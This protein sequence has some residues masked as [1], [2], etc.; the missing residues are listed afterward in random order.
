MGMSIQHRD[1]L[2]TQIPLEFCVN[3]SSSVSKLV[4]ASVSVSGS[5]KP[6][7][8]EVIFCVDYIR[9]VQTT[10]T[11]SILRIDFK[12]TRLVF[13]PKIKTTQVKMKCTQTVRRK[14]IEGFSISISFNMGKNVLF[15][16]AN[17]L[18]FLLKRFCNF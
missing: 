14:Q 8:S 16:R 5:E 6:L 4:F 10:V 15:S 7:Q 1:K 9:K 17:I 3:L 13:Q 18:V 2:F 12:L 11:Y